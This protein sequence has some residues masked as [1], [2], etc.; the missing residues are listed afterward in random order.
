L[1]ASGGREG[2][3][4]LKEGFAAISGIQSEDRRP[5]SS[6]SIMESAFGR[7]RFALTFLVDQTENQALLAPSCSTSLMRRN[8]S[9]KCCIAIICRLACV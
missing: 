7:V 8:I 3:D 4:S 1:V 6:S 2:L 5:T 9:G